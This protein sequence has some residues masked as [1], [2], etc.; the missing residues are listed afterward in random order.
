MKNVVHSLLIWTA[1]GVLTQ[2]S[3]AADLEKAK[4]QP[5]SV[6][7]GSETIMGKEAI[8]VTKDPA[9]K[10]FDEPTFAKLKGVGFQDGTI[11]VK[12]LSR[13]LKD[14][15]DFARGFIGIA[16]RIHEDNSK[17]ECI[18]VRPGN[19][20]V[21]DQVRRNHSI[22]YFAYP[23]FKFQRLR[24]EAPEKYESYADMGLDEWIDLKIVVKG[25]QAKLFV[26]G[27]KQPA[28]IVNDL[29]LGDDVS[30]G[31]GLFVDVGTEGYFSE[32]RIE[33]D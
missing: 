4:L 11:E 23:D 15:P 24:K 21:D 29:K 19:A 16:F 17:F 31:I 9:V 5:V 2:V 13:L 25:T 32:L 12:V 10:E 6:S 28:L 33:N 30:G 26:N 14:A 1:I 22:Q 18:Y 8:R 3:Y 27:A 7:V 20:R